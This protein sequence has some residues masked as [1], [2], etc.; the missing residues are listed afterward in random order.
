MDT[1]S[2]SPEVAHGAPQLAV[3]G[4]GSVEQHSAH[5]PIDTDFFIAQRGS[6]QVAGAL[7]ALLLPTLPY[8]VCLEHRGFAGVVG[9]KPDTVR[10]MVWDIAESVGLWGVR[11]LALV[12]F[13]GGNFILNPAAR[14]WN[15]EGKWP[16]ILPVDFYG[17]LT[18]VGDNLHACE[19]EGSIM[20]HFAPERVHLERAVDFVPAFAREDLTVLGMKRVT[21]RGVWGYPTRAAADKGARWFAEGVQKSAARI[22]RLR[23]AC[24]EGQ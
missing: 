11:Y 12:I 2:T 14:E 7:D 16:R 21:P 8:S 13:H 19:V 4:V 3:I 17:G 15:M 6:A 24:E 18:G 1:S 10:R 5:L 22:T 23:A 20:L 9:L